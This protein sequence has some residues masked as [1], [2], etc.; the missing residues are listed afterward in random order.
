VNDKAFI[1][2]LKTKFPHKIIHICVK[3]SKNA[4]RKYWTVI[5]QDTERIGENPYRYMAPIP[6]ARVTVH[7]KINPSLEYDC[8]QLAKGYA[9]PRGDFWASEGFC[10]TPADMLAI[11]RFC[12]FKFSHIT[13]NYTDGRE[14]KFDMNEPIYIPGRMYPKIVL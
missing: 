11:L 5:H 13:V 12:H 7:F 3:E 4:M 14:Q 6:F 10:I 8:T 2:Y 9:G 1:A